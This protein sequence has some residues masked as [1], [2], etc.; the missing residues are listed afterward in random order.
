MCLILFAIF[1]FAE[2]WQKKDA[3]RVYDFQDSIPFYHKLSIMLF[4]QGR[5]CAEAEG[6]DYDEEG[7]DGNDEDDE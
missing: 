5:L 7:I 3:C 4:L 2:I 1:H 6:L